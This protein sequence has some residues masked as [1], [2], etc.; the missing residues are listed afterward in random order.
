M[1]IKFPLKFN[2]DLAEFIGILLGD[3]S[4][5]IYKCKAG[6]KI[7]IQHKLQI[8]CNSVDDKEYIRYLEVLIEKLFSVK[9]KKSFREGKTCDLRLF[10]KEIIIFLLHKIGLELSPKWKR[11]KIPNRYLRNDLEFDVLRGYFDTDGSVV[12]ANNNGTI[13]PRLEMKVCPSPMQ[14]QFIDIL[15]RHK[16]N[17]GAYDIGK[18][19]VRIQLNGKKQLKRW[20]DVIG[21]K[22]QKHINK[23]LIAG[24]GIP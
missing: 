6:D 16:F 9:P 13:Y 1:N 7:K 18:G 21:F 24:V 22:N 5:G 14:K 3:G 8:T 15:K 17:F 4:I 12:L 2:S 10:N 19:K 20:K 23:V 11:A